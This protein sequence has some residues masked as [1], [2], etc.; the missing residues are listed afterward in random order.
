MALDPGSTIT[1]S[2]ESTVSAY[3]PERPLLP[4]TPDVRLEDQNDSA[5]VNNQVS[6]WAFFCFSKC[7]SYSLLQIATNCI[8]RSH[9]F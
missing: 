5:A 6:Q 7:F 8:G 9:C 3:A 4:G 1:L 2:D